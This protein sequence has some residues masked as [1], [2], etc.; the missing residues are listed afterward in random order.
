MK[1]P[2]CAKRSVLHCS[3]VTNF[4][5]GFFMKNQGSV[6]IVTGIYETTKRNQPGS[7]LMR[8]GSYSALFLQLPHFQFLKYALIS[9]NNCTSLNKK[10]SCSFRSTNEKHPYLLLAASDRLKRVKY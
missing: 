6:L 7:L 1:E 5:T 10:E 4:C 2:S 8:A 9:L 3:Y